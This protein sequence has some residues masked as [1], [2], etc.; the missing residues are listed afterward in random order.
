MISLLC[1]VSLLACPHAAFGSAPARDR[2]GV[3]HFA[4]AADSSFDRFSYA[5]SAASRRW[6]RL[7]YWRMR[8]YSPYFD[9]RTSWYSSAWTYKDDYAIYP[10]ERL[11]ADFYLRDAR[12]RRL[13]IPF[14]CRRGSCPQFAADIGSPAFRAHWIAEAKD[15][16]RHGYRGIFVDDVNMELRISDG[17]GN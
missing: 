17:N 10:G 14:D 3:V 6:M 13:Y 16:Y 2:E 9:S 11:P 12:G 4:K 5:P 15:D 1:A 8:A 7:K